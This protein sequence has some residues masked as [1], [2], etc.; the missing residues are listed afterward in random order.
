MHKHF[1]NQNKRQPECKIKVKRESHDFGSYFEVA[2]EFYFD[3][4]TSI[5]DAF[6]LEE[7]SPSNW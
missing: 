3:N 5:N 4:E 1:V 7:N 2:A 6:W